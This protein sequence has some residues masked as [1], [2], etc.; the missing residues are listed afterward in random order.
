MRTLQRLLQRFYA[1]VDQTA[2]RGGK[3]NLCE[4]VVCGPE[5]LG[6]SKEGM[7]ALRDCRELL[8]RRQF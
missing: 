1:G 8:Q 7:R 3:I 6:V 2:P 5:L 4:F